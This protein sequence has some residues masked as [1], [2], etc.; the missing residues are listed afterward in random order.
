[1]VQ[2]AKEERTFFYDAGLIIRY[3][4]KGRTTDSQADRNKNNP[5]GSLEHT[6]GVEGEWVTVYY[7]KN[8]FDDPHA[9]KIVVRK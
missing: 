8:A 6:K 3:E 4:K 2:G 7:E 9:V 1:V 5:F